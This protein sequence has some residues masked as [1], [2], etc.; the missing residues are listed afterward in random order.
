MDK[1]FTTVLISS[2]D[3]QTSRLFPWIGRGMLFLILLQLCWLPG[4]YAQSR[5]VSGSV[6]S[7][8]DKGPLPGVSV[9]VKGTTNGTTTQAD[10]TFSLAIPEGAVSLVFSFIGF[11]T[12]EVPVNTNQTKITVMLAPDAKALNE[13]VVVGFGEQKKA[14][15]VS[16]IT[17][18]N[19]KELKG[20]T[21]NL[22]NAIA[23]KVAGMISFQQSGEPGIG[24]DNSQ[25]YIR[26][27]STFGTGKRDPLILIDGIESTPTDMARLQP[28]DISDF[29][30]L[31][32]AAASSIYGARGANGV[33][34][35]NT[36]LGK[37]GVTTFSF[38]AENR[39]STNTRNFQLADNIS[40]MTLANEAT[41]SRSPEAIL[42]YTQNKINH[43]MEGA[44]PYLYPNNNW[45]DQLIKDY[46]FNQGYNLNISGGTPKGRYYIAGTFNRDNGVLNVDPINNFNSNIKL[47][48][49]SIR[50]NID[51]N[52]TKNLTLIA[53]IYGQFD[54]Y[55][56]PIGTNGRSGG[57]TT[58]DNALRA[59]PVMFPARYPSEKIS[60]LEHPLFGSARTIGGTGL[61]TNTLYMNPY[62]E[63]VKGF[64]TIK[65]SNLN[66]QIEL[67][68]NMDFITKGLAARA[69]SY[70]KRTSRFSLNRN[71]NPFYYY[72]IIDPTT[73]DYSIKVLNDGA[74]GSVGTTGTEYLNYVEPAENKV[75]ES[76]FWA[77]AVLD[78]NQVFAH[79]HSVGGMLVSYIS[80]YET[81]SPGSLIRSL[82]QRNNGTSG[83]L[84][85]GY[86]DR[87][88]FEFNFGYNGSERFAAK[89]R[90]GF[91]PSGGLGYRISNEKFFEPLKSVIDNLKFRATYGVVGNDAI[92]SR[93]ERF[94]YMSNVNLNDGVYGY[95]FGK[96]DGA[97]VY[98]RPGISVTR[99][100]NDAITWE[101]SKQLNIGMDLNLVNSLELIVDAFKQQRTQILQPVTY[102]DNAAGLM[103]T[104]LSYYG[105]LNSQGVDLSANYRKNLSKDFSA[106]LRGT[107][108]FATSKVVKMDELAYTSGL[109]HL[110]RSGHSASQT[111]GYIAERLFV[112]EE[113]VA[114][115]PVQF[116]DKGLLAGDIKYRDVNRDGVVD[117]DDMVPLGYP[118]QPE[119]I[120]GFGS[121]MRYKKFDFNFYFQ[122]SARSSFF[123]NPSAI[124]PFLVNGGNQNGLLKAIADDHWSPENPNLYAF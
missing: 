102:I 13:V 64:Q 54:D 110:T 39:V 113:E 101:R 3:R 73:G 48:N 25:F 11:T 72:S 45:M 27:L 104:P 59:N 15:V 122:G 52:L 19:V 62:A 51:L 8:E 28:D 35:I 107:F 69:M 49:Y 89:N 1:N 17:S 67:R 50:T 114:N 46:S 41:L 120:Y 34:L 103:A 26:G 4:A 86:D 70:V 98:G 42:P 87:Y 85:Y 9:L 115:S 53:R 117:S 74:T 93:D 121:S 16:S 119:I 55:N 76:Q 30:V 43:T 44:D 123:I 21:S 99:Y 47:N 79:K 12:K 90:F 23:G 36:K 40:Y 109:A 32:D 105:A 81:G 124:Q 10:G 106:E 5:T 56:G 29:S 77:Q 71:Y 37:E 22:T 68:Q 116:G 100:A 66:P 20:P 31:K 60:Y 80:S 75:I 94:L 111:W 118:T 108:T 38:R 14:S 84:T 96:N 97:G 78:Y 63:M 18:V 57:A 112:D 65:A 61:E 92:G 6:T 83:R 2:N 82:P 88:L 91:F 58:F 33:V 95:S 24:T 7:S